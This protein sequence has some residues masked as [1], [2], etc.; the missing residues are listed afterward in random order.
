MVSSMPESRN[1]LIICK[2][3]NWSTT[4]QWHTEFWTRV[5]T[6]HRQLSGIS[7]VVDRRRSVG[8]IGISEMQSQNKAQT[9]QTQNRAA[10]R[11]CACPWWVNWGIESRADA[12]ADQTKWNEVSNACII[13]FQ[14]NNCSDFSKGKSVDE[15]W[16]GLE[17]MPGVVG[18]R[19]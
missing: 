13:A 17:S 1:L 7:Q 19:F 5:I 12:T 18:D 16:I 4:L 11:S 6:S 3:F 9:K 14:A 8:S 2:N 10:D 15:V